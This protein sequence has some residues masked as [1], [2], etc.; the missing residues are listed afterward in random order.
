MPK[1]QYIQNALA[2][3]MT[4]GVIQLNKEYPLLNAL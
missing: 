2:V 1:C 3:T 4:T